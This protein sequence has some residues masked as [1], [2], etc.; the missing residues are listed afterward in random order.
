MHYIFDPNLSNED[1]QQ[2]NLVESIRNMAAVRGKTVFNR[3]STKRAVRTQ[4]IGT[5]LLPLGMGMGLAQSRVEMETIDETPTPKA[6][7]EKTASKED[8]EQKVQETNLDGPETAEINVSGLKKRSTKTK[9][10]ADDDD[11]ASAGEK[12]PL[13]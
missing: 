13:C 2:K 1:K 4:L 5:A 9:G 12:D 10:G 7:D 8:A 6:E 3:K 11:G